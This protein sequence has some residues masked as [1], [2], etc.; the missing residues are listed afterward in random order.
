MFPGSLNKK[1]SFTENTCF[2]ENIIKND[3]YEIDIIEE[4]ESEE[5][6]SEEESEKIVPE[7]FN[8]YIND[9]KEEKIM[10]IT[11]TESKY[12]FYQ[13]IDNIL[14][15]DLNKIK[16]NRRFESISIC[17]FNTHPDSTIPF[18]QYYLE[19][20][21][22]GVLDFPTICHDDYN[23]IYEELDLFLNNII[24]K[25]GNIKGY[26]VKGYTVKDYSVKDYVVKGFKLFKDTNYI[27]VDVGK[28][29]IN[30]DNSCSFLALI[31]EITNTKKIYDIDINY[32]VTDLF[33]ENPELIFLKDELNK[34]YEIPIAAYQW[35][36]ERR[37]SFTF[38]FGIIK[39]DHTSIMGPYFYFSNYENTLE[40]I[41]K[42]EGKYGIIRCCLFLGNIK[43][44]MNF[45]EDETD[46]SL[47]KK[48]LI[49]QNN[50]HAILTWRISDHDGKWA[51]LYDSVYLGRTMLD[52]GSLLKDTP[53]WVIKNHS[54]QYT[55]SYKIIG[56]KLQINK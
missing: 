50:K 37:L 45:L 24:T 3:N 8:N 52:D 31:D 39:S 29:E 27:F 22:L 6:D 11:K 33:I 2:V 55:L 17:I 44:P 35:V 41:N 25:E 7:N 10:D 13:D 54:Q 9:E 34:K 20:N 56:K 15:P 14:D 26:G 49:K 4:E 38:M 30:V 5:L 28:N 19:Y 32:K 43:I 23:D 47:F 16:K 1:T 51:D 36:E 48:E 42:K 46:E 12:C 18:L 21:F 53:Q 40:K